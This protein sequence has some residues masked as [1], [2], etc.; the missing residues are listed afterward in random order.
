NFE[1]I[2]IEFQII[3]DTIVVVAPIAGGPSDALGIMAGD[4]IVKINNEKYSKINNEWVFKQLR[5]P[6]GTKVDVTIQR[7]GISGLLEFNI[8]RDK[9][10]LYSVDSHFMVDDK[11][12][13]ISLTKFSQTTFD[14]VLSAMD[15]LANK[16]MKRVILDL[17]NNS[18]GYMNEAVKIS[19]LFLDQNKMIVYTKSRIKEF[20]EEYRA[21]I[22]YRYEQ[23]PIIVLVNNGSASASEIVSG[24]IQD[25]DRGLIVGE[26]TF[27]KGL[28]QRQFSLP[29]NS[30]LRL[31]IAKYYTPVGRL[32]QRDYSK[33]QSLE[34]C[35]RE[36]LNRD[37]LEGE[38]IE[39]VAEKDTSRPVFKTNSG[40]KVYGGGGITPDYI[41]KS[42]TLTKYSSQL[43]RLNLFY[44]FILDYLDRNGKEIQSQYKDFEKFKKQ[45]ILTDDMLNQFIE[46]AKQKKLEFVKEDFEKDKE[47][48][49]ARLKAQ[50]ARSFWRNDGWYPILLEQDNQFLKA[51]SLFPEAEKLAKLK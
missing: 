43:L 9:I 4:R 10:P 37:S 13:Y 33:T 40:R 41:V 12:G 20:I 24:A 51:L 22:P 44:T 48:I 32:I 39:H 3:N 35:Y 19:D 8:T 23:T 27:G 28:V 2:G 45:F 30:A 5:G 25:W 38:N 46:Y 26:S 11:T 42:Q 34:E 7:P 50:V 31:T 49:R 21:S 36:S 16:G 17:R 1:G 15:D 14:E 6:K 29:D 47:Y 18:G